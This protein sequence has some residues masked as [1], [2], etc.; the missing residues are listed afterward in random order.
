VVSRGSAN[1]TAN[2]FSETIALTGIADGGAVDLVCQSND[3]G[4]ARSRVLIAN[5]VA[6]VTA[7]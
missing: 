5:R 6:N 4:Q 3:P 7:Q 2:E 1:V